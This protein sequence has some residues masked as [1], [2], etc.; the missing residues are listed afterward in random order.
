MSFTI[1]T[2]MANILKSKELDK[3]QKM[4]LIK[5]YTEDM[6]DEKGN[7][8]EKIGNQEAVALMMALELNAL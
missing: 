1:P 8:L 4:N 2:S 7:K 3:D 6:N 5:S